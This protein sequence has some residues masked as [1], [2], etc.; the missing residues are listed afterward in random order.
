[1]RADVLYFA[2]IDESPMVWSHG[3]LWRTT[4]ADLAQGVNSD[5][6]PYSNVM[7]DTRRDYEALYRT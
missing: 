3:E 5:D 2:D 7:G 1:M 6:S 4:R